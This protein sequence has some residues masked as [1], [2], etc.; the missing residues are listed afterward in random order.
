MSDKPRVGPSALVA[1][2]MCLSVV[3]VV[4]GCAVNKPVQ[5]MGGPGAN[6]SI[7]SQQGVFDNATVKQSESDL[8]AAVGNPTSM[9]PA[10]TAAIGQYYIYR[11]G[12]LETRVNIRAGAV[13]GV[14][15]IDLT[16]GK[17]KILQSK[18]LK[19]ITTTP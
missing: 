18:S 9:L 6:T 5:E 10:P 1:A 15:L 17:E 8:L 16:C 11:Y 19:S 14:E 12:D 3:A 2:I 4:A 7:F 13:F